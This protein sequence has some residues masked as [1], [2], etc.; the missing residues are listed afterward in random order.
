MDNF[1]KISYFVCMCT[2]PFRDTKTTVMEIFFNNK[3]WLGA[4]PPT[5]EDLKEQITNGDFSFVLKLRCFSQSIR[6]SDGY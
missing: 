1:S 2:T 3:H 5:L 6:G 4:N